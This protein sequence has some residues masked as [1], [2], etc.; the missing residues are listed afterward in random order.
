M[1]RKTPDQIKR[2]IQTVEKFSKLVKFN[3]M[4]LEA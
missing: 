1:K 3:T 4:F 2:K